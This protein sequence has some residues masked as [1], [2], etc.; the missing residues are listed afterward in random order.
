MGLEYTY[1]RRENVRAAS[2]NDT[3][4]TAQQ[5]LWK[6]KEDD[7]N[8]EQYSAFES[9][10]DLPDFLFV[11]DGNEVVITENTERFNKG[12]G[13]WYISSPQT[14]LYRFYLY[15]GKVTESNEYEREKVT[16]L[17]PDDNISSEKTMKN[18]PAVFRTSPFWGTV[19]MPED[20]DGEAFAD[21]KTEIAGLYSPLFLPTRPLSKSTKTIPKYRRSDTQR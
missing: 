20:C 14:R 2:L 18:S 13:D 7:Q 9:C 16:V 6:L 17:F 5:L 19:V 8:A 21:E 3:D 11:C 15:S 10:L 1:N 4:S 12:K